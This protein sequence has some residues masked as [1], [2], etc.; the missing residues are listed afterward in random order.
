MCAICYFVAYNPSTFAQ[1]LL[2]LCRLRHI[3]SR[4]WSS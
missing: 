1:R 4:R 2:P 3:H